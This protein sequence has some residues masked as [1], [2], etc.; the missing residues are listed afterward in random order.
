MIEKDVM[1]TDRNEKYFASAAGADTDSN[2]YDPSQNAN[3]EKLHNILVTYT[4]FNFDT[5]YCQVSPLT[6]LLDFCTPL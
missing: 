3:L 6:N 1:R 4:M 2:R 5:G